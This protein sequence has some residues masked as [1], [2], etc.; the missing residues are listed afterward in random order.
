MTERRLPSSDEE[1]QSPRT[2]P[3][4]RAR[5]P[6]LSPEEAAEA[7][8]HGASFRALPSRTAAEVGLDP[9]R[10]NREQLERLSPEKP[11]EMGGG[12]PLFTREDR[13]GFLVLLPEGFGLTRVVRLAPRERWE[14][15]LRAVHGG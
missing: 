1:A 15:A 8:A 7:A 11:G 3:E 10:S 13:D 9:Q 4:L 5:F 2:A 12:F 6:W 14:A